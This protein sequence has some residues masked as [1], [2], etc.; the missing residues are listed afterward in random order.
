M[1]LLTSATSFMKFDLLLFVLFFAFSNYGASAEF[2]YSLLDK[3]LDIPYTINNE[4]MSL[5]TYMANKKQRMSSLCLRIL[6]NIYDQQFVK[7]GITLTQDE[8]NKVKQLWLESYPQKELYEKSIKTLSNTYKEVYKILLFMKE[9]S[10][11]PNAA[12]SQYSKENKIILSK[13]QWEQLFCFS[14]LEGL[15]KFMKAN[16]HDK[17]ISLISNN[18]LL[19]L[20]IRLLWEKMLAANNQ[21]VTQAANKWKAEI[22]ALSIKVPEE[23]LPAK[24]EVLKTLGNL[25]PPKAEILNAQTRPAYDELKKLAK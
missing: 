18:I 4:E 24:E 2:R 8:K 10:L 20:Q 6:R 13:R 5:H 16:E 11:T 19:I 3:P 12:Y 14:S 25:F 23:Y 15:Q 22:S 21:E 9:H 7:Y 17:K 1:K